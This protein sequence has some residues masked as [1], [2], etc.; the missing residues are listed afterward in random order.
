MLERERERRVGGVGQWDAATK[1]EELNRL[2]ESG[3]EREREIFFFIRRER[4]ITQGK[5]KV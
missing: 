2:V 5:G 1:R 4:E 3:G